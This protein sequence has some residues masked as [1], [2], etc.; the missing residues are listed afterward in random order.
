MFAPFF[1]NF[2]PE[3]GIFVEMK[4]KS[5]GRNADDSAYFGNLFVFGFIESRQ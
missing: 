3:F 1:K 4:I 5:S 2:P